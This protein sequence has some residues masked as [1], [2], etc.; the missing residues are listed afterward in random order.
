MCFCA[1]EYKNKPDSF[2]SWGGDQHLELILCLKNKNKRWKM[3]IRRSTPPAELSVDNQLSA[4][5]TRSVPRVLYGVQK[6]KKKKK[7]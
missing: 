1:A 3:S 2:D 7:K 6:K 5:M 4:L